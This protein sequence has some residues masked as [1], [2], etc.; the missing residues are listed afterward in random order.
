MYGFTSDNICY[1]D[2]IWHLKCF[3]YCHYM[4]DKEDCQAISVSSHFIYQ[5]LHHNL[6][7]LR[8]PLLQLWKYH[9]KWNL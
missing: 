4:D 7:D 1:S 8:K 2:Y 9:C 6:V 5:Q 3:A